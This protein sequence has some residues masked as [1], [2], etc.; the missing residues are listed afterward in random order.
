[1]VTV[2]F[3]T[4]LTNKILGGFDSIPPAATKVFVA[5]HPFVFYI[6]INDVILFEGRVLVPEYES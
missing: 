6:K 5:D 1:V 4:G 2:E 3:G